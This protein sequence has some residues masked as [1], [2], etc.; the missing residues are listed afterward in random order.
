MDGLLWEARFG[1]ILA[2][3][4]E[5]LDEVVRQIQPDPH[6]FSVGHK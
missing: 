5:L 4:G 3:F 2:L 6:E 1:Q